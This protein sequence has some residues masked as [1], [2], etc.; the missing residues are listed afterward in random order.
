MATQT[1][2]QQN[3]QS[4]SGSQG[5]QGGQGSQGQQGKSGG[6]TDHAG[7][8][9]D[10]MK[11]A[12]AA[13]VS[14]A[15]EQASAAFGAVKDKA[16]EFAS[17]AVERADDAVSAAGRRI[18]QLADG[19]RDNTPNEGMLGAASNRVADTL[20]ASGKYLEEH[21]VTGMVDDMTE[22]IRRNPIPAVLVGV[23]IGFILARATSR[24]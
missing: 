19:I 8:V 7:K 2:N 23:G 15:G 17:S 22:V 13:L 18:E 10:E 24:S 11:Q 1:R 6:F 14:S 3:E 20:H 21:G 9:V 5:H 4:K 12:G 16:S